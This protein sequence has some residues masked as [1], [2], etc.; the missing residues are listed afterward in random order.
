MSHSFTFK[1]A[2]FIVKS[3]APRQFIIKLDCFKGR[4]TFAPTA[5]YL[6]WT[7]LRTTNVWHFGTQTVTP[8][9]IHWQK[10]G[11]EICSGPSAIKKT[12][13]LE[14]LQLNWFLTRLVPREDT[15]LDY[16]FSMRLRSLSVRGINPVKKALV[17]THTKFKVT[18][19]Q[20]ALMPMSP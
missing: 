19:R 18:W 2:L 6:R 16:F 1:S 7:E 12:L 17:N 5:S 20:N 4:R 9:S 10:Y 8:K 11:N 3:R 14:I 13:I 15:W